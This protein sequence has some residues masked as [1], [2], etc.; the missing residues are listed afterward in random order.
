MAESSRRPSRASVE[1]SPATWALP[2]EAAFQGWVGRTFE[3]DVGTPSVS[4]RRSKSRRGYELMLQQRFVRDYLQQNSPYRGLLLYHGLGSGK[5]CAAI[6]A[7]EALRQDAALRRIVV[8]LPAALQSNYTKEV[9]RCGGAVFRESQSWRFETVISTAANTVNADDLELAAAVDPKLIRAHGGRWVPDPVGG[10]PF[11]QLDESQREHVAAQVE[12][13][14][15][16]THE[17]VNYNGLNRHRVEA[18]CEKGFD[19]AVVVIDEVHNFTVGVSNGRQLERLYQALMA[20]RRCKLVLLSGTPMV[21]NP[22]ELALLVNLAHGYV[23]VMDYV[24]RRPMDDAAA[25][26]LSACPHVHEFRQDV[27][28]GRPMVSVR[29]L[30]EGFVRIE[31]EQGR[32]ARAGSGAG[33]DDG[34]KMALAAIEAVL[35]AG[36]GIGDA[37]PLR[38]DI[39]LLPA[40]PAEFRKVFVDTQTNK[41]KNADV[42]QRRILGTISYFRGHAESLYPAL[43]K[44]LIVR[45]PLSVRQMS[46][47]TALRHA[48]IRNEELERKRAAMQRSAGGVGGDDD[49]QPTYRAFTRAV[50]NFAFPEDVPRPRRRDVRVSLMDAEIG[51]DGDP[52]TS[53]ADVTRAYERELEAAVKK[54][55][56]QPGRLSLASGKLAEL[57]PKYAAVVRHLLESRDR[58]AIVYSQFK[59]AEGINLLAAGMDMNGFVELRLRRKAPLKPGAPAGDL[60]LHVVHPDAPGDAPR[61]IVYSND[62]PAAAKVA[63]R[64]FNG[65][66]DEGVPPAVLRGLRRLA[67]GDDARMRN[68]RGE[69]VQAMLLTRSG[70]EGISTRNVREVH[71]IE[72]F[73]HANRIEQVVGRARRAYSHDDLPDKDRTVDVYIYLATFAPDQA[74]EHNRDG[75]KTSDEFVHDVAVRKR[76]LLKEVTA[77]AMSAAVDCRLHRRSDLSADTCY[78]PPAGTTPDASNYQLDIGEDVRDTPHAAKLVAVKTGGRMYYMDP[79]TGTLYDYSALKQRGQVVPIGRVKKTS[80]E[81]PRV[82]PP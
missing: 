6:A 74:K 76:K 49:S 23:H 37:G 4:S 59:R 62:D 78:S 52:E 32:I 31:G 57:S 18:L 58:K 35:D 53:D 67:G 45:T 9:T 22:W 64:V 27:R 34:R 20:A 75:G 19:D 12:S 33:S 38:R 56:S 40:D 11:D 25:A 68:V 10:R 47:Y 28:M 66:V 61:Y 77:C 36:P 48:E 29:L 46:E 79:Q 21:N 71:V 54:L 24:L 44:M 80:S 60:E 30:P 5:T 14:V 50:C 51:A 65:E 13:A 70:A 7:S 16:R 3:Y 2:S 39:T 26:Q 17:F 1:V 41:L 63:L 72:P 81:P 8:M 15:R 43:R 69:I 55:R 73:W 42:L 82:A